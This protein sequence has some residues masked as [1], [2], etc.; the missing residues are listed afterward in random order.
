[1][2]EH[3][4]GEGCYT[5]SGRGNDPQEHSSALSGSQALCRVP[6]LELSVLR[7][8]QDFSF[9]LLTVGFQASFCKT[10]VRTPGETRSEKCEFEKQEGQTE[11][12]QAM[13]AWAGGGVA[14]FAS[15]C[16]CCDSSWTAPKADLTKC[17]DR[18]FS[19]TGLSP[20]LEITKFQGERD[21][22]EH[23]AQPFSA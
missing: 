9:Y 14:V 8:P 10:Q 16:L 22:V 1:M 4:R 17:P 2:K 23:L 21:I 5:S 11:C 3:T 15:T 7:T 20:C 13:L 6:W 18:G 19:P 12:I